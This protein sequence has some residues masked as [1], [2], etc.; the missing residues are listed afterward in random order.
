MTDEER[1]FRHRKFWLWEFT[2]RNE[3]YRRDYDVFAQTWEQFT[4]IKNYRREDIFETLVKLQGHAD[5]DLVEP[6]KRDKIHAVLMAH[7]CPAVLAGFSHLRCMKQGEGGVA[8]PHRDK[9]PQWPSW[10]VW[11]TGG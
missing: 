4:P 1:N 11:R 5:L 9:W 3:E 8:S 6:T 10:P 2:R 7:N